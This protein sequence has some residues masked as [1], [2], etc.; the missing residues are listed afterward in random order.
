MPA[1]ALGLFTLPYNGM[2]AEEISAA[3]SKSVVYKAIPS[4]PLTAP[5][6][7]LKVSLDSSCKKSP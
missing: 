6:L 2:G 3:E 1:I 5:S 7:L 4:L